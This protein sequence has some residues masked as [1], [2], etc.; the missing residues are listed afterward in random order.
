[1]LQKKYF[2]EQKR[3]LYPH[4]LRLVVFHGLAIVQ[5]RYPCLSWVPFHR[6]HDRFLGIQQRDFVKDLWMNFIKDQIFQP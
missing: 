2:Q 5:V 6:Y 4:I 1:M 3:L